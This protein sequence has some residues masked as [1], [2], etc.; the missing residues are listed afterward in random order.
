MHVILAGA[1]TLLL[2]A[3]PAAVAQA[4]AP[5]TPPASTR[6]VTAAGSTDGAIT[7]VATARSLGD[8]ILDAQTDD[9]AI[10]THLDHAHVWPYLSNF[11]AMGLAS[12]TKRT[13]D[14]AYA[15]ASWRWLRWYAAHQDER[16]FVT[17]YRAAD[18]GWASTGDMDS[19]DAYAGT[20]LLAVETTHAA[21]PD[22]ASL[23]ALQ[24]AI[25]LAVSAIEATQ[26]DDGLTW[27]KPSWHVKY[28]MDQAETYA[29]LRAA[30]RLAGRLGDTVLAARATADAAALQTG[31]DAL[32]DTTSGTYDWAV[33]ENGVHQPTD[34]GQLY[35]DA[36]QQ[37]WAVAFGLVPPARAAALMD[38]VTAAQPAWDDPTA[39]A[40]V[41]GERRAAGY[42]VPAAWAVAGVGE[43]GPATEAGDRILAAADADDRL[44]P[45]TPSDAGQLLVLGD[46]LDDQRDDPPPTT[47]PV[48]PSGNT[49]TTDQAGD[50]RRLK[51][52]S[53]IDTAVAVAD[54]GW[55]AATHVLLATADQFPDALSAGALAA[56]LDAPLLL[57]ARDVLP[58]AVEQALHRLGV[59]EIAVIGGA[60]A[61]SDAVV[62]HLRAAGYLVRRYAGATRYE[63]AAAV[64]GAVASSA[65]PPPD[66]LLLASGLDSAD[67][68]AAGAFNALGP[69]PLLLAGAGIQD[70]LA[71]L[72]QA[73]TQ[74]Q[75]TVVG[76][77]AAV[78]RAV[79]VA[80]VPDGVPIRRLAGSNRFLTGLT[81]AAAVLERLGSDPVRL[82]VASGQGFADALTAGA[83]T[84]RVRGLLLLVPPD[85]LDGV[86]AIRTFLRT[87]R[88]RF[89]GVTLV[90]GTAAL[91]ER[92]SDQLAADLGLVIP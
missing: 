90:G 1:L 37:A 78:A 33:H 40:L 73:A 67:A 16:G 87:N 70:T 32:W 80:L 66:D 43:N 74:R 77:I 3:A 50:V 81:V 31:V 13:G 72:L 26:D 18:G 23:R 20:F 68:L 34:L 79:A 39:T 56:Q 62:D 15:G 36:M 30:A 24:P 7:S 91:S 83:L 75:V 41:D 88:D 38:R 47:G 17:D 60:A 21:H 58:T 69:A 29:G 53:R 65:D 71:T 85:D 52:S 9:G 45:F 2:A 5:A 76:G 59:R 86:P 92:V 57:T 11:A 4:A 28:L 82:V 89:S 27:A 10:A 8:W 46:R 14:Q 55:D 44:W 19:T 51:G 63:T 84:S 22:T 35:P 12:A 64:A 25:A 54:A 6:S 61:V 42:W 49:A 48:R